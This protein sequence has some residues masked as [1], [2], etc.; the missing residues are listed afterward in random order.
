MSSGG[1]P[2]MAGAR[3]CAGMWGERCRRGRCG[4]SSSRLAWLGLSS[5][6]GDGDAV[7]AKA[8]SLPQ[9]LS[10]PLPRP[11]REAS[12]EEVA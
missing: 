9:A 3:R 1:T 11:P 2:P 5:A 10:Q 12:Y 8:R 7:F 6:A 4:T